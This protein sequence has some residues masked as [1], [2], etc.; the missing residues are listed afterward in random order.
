MGP[1]RLENRSRNQPSVLSFEDPQLVTTLGTLPSSMAEIPLKDWFW[2]EGS[3]GKM[4][5][6]YAQSPRFTLQHFIN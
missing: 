3:A 4:L 6:Q 1:E 2:R 5:A